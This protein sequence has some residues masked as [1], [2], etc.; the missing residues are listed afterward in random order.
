[1]AEARLFQALSDPTRLKIV[2]ILAAGPRNVT[3]IVNLVRA[4]QPAVSRHLRI[5]REVGLIHDRRL[6]K[7]VEYSLDTGRVEEACGWL[8]ELAQAGVSGGSGA[9]AGDRSDVGEGAGTR[10]EEPRADKRQAEGGKGV[11]RRVSGP[12]PVATGQ[13]RLKRISPL[14]ARRGMTG[15]SDC[16]VSVLDEKGPAEKEAAAWVDAPPGDRQAGGGPPGRAM[17]ERPRPGRKA[18]SVKGAGIRS[19]GK[20]AK[21]SVRSKPRPKAGGKRGAERKPETEP[22][23]VVEREKDSMDDFLL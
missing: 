10:V 5:L 6:G 16:A 20:H 17:Q 9:R 19:S 13:G 12:R 15:A 1:M 8:G 7:E 2:G 3:G 23:Y 4:A 22:T 21:P 18:R 14:A 11:V